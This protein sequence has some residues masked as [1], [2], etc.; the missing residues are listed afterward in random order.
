MNKI[1]VVKGGD[2]AY[3]SAVYGGVD[4]QH[5]VPN[6]G[7]LITMN[8]VSNNNPVSGGKKSKKGGM[9][10]EMLVPIVLVAANTLIKRRK[11]QK[12]GFKSADTSSLNAMSFSGGQTLQGSVPLALVMA[13]NFVKRRGRSNKKSKKNYRKS[14]STRRRK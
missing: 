12:G 11:S 5:A 8:H 4:A 2:Y 14:R 13:N 1:P 10:K 6:G 9:L 7:N 3:A